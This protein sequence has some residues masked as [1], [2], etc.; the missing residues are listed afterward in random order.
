MIWSYLHKLR[1]RLVERLLTFCAANSD[2]I[3]FDLLDEHVREV[4]DDVWIV[5]ITTLQLIHELTPHS[6]NVDTVKISVLSLQ[7]HIARSDTYTQ[8]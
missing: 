7:Y 1:L 6:V 3:R 4:R 5:V 2:T 8:F